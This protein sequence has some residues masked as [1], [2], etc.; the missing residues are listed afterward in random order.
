MSNLSILDRNIIHGL[1]S[2]DA[3]NMYLRARDKVGPYAAEQIAYEWLWVASM[4]RS[5]LEDCAKV[6]EMDADESLFQFIATRYF[7][8]RLP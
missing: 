2:E 4:V 6:H 1:A 5:L 7:H 8:Y 3:E